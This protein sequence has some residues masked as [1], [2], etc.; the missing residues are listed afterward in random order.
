[1]MRN[2]ITLLVAA[3]IVV[4]AIGQNNDAVL[5]DKIT[6]AVM[7]VYDD[8]LAANPNDYNVIFARANQHYYDGDYT[9]ALADVNQALLL[10]PKT[11]QELRF[12]EYILRARISDARKDYS[13]ELADLLLAQELQP[14]S[15]ACTDLIAKANLKSG[16]L[17]AAEK[18]FKTILRAESM[19][20]D[21]MY[22][23]AQVELA[24]GNKKAALSQ[25]SKAVEL[26]RVEPQVYVNRADIQAKLG[27]VDAAVLDLLQGMSVGDGGN[28]A[29]SLFDLSDT[30]YDA[31]M[32]SLSSLADRAT[33]GGAI[34]RYLRANIAIDHSRYGQALND[35]NL[36][37]RNNLYDSPMM[38]YN[39]GKCCLELG[40]YDEA[41][42]YV[43]QAI[44]GDG[45]QPEY[46]LLK[47]LAEYNVGEGG[48]YDAAMEVLN[49]CSAKSPQNVPMLVA[50]ASLLSSKGKDMEAL[51]YL[52]AAIANEPANAEALIARAL[53]LKRLDKLNL[54]VKDLNTMTMLSNDVYDLKGIA[55][56]ELGRDNEALKW[57]NS[58]TTTNLP[59]GENFF[60]AAIFMALRGDNY[61]AMEYAQKAVDAGYAS[62]YRLLYDE[63]S[64]LNLKSLRDDP[65]FQLLMDKAMRNFVETN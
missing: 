27:D 49:Q 55:L 35:L 58:I 9:A 24:R 33:D 29:R 64:P 32:R 45:N 41:L 2:L 42:A 65:G 62:K 22:G 47:S 53:T 31:V 43:N 48:N 16:N 6:T 8:H 11:D 28:A 1:M 18:A 50:K 20:Y 10:T 40:R 44:A 4:P 7:K 56:S 63:L 34:Y 37:R 12:D 15:L 52:N 17:D 39:M 13:A 26:F 19:N 3:T 14:K 46:Y 36:M 21:A 61:K 54:A 38:K 60:Y 30:N 25:V 51:G 57:L 5:Q 59:G 23:M